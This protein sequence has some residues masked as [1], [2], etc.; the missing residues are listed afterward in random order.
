MIKK[1]VK[2]NRSDS[3]ARSVLSVREHGKM[4]KTPERLRAARWSFSPKEKGL[5]CRAETRQQT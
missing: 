1:V 4:T 3:E 2:Q 5:G